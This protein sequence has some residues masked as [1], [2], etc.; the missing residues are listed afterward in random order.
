MYLYGFNK[1]NGTY[2]MTR[3]QNRS[4]VKGHVGVIGQVIVMS[5]ETCGSRTTSLSKT[6]KQFI[7]Q[8]I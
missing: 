8:I 1:H 6:Y 7:L 2:V 4:W 5:V 3:D